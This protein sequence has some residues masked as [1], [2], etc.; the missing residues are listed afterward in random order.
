MTNRTLTSTA[1]AAILATVALTG[2]ASARAA[3]A[4]PA[5]PI[6]FLVPYP[7]GGSTDPIVRTIGQKLTEAW[8]QQIVIDNRAGAGGNLATDTTAKSAPDGYTLLL[9]T[10]STICINPSLY[11][12]LPFDPIKDLQP[13]SLV[14]SGFYLLAV[15]SG[16]PAASVKELVALAKSKPGQ[17]NYA[18]GGAGSAPHLAMELLKQMAH[19]DIA[20]VPYKGTGPALT[21][22]VGGHV[23]MLFGSAVSITP[24]QKAGR[25]RVLA[26]TG[27]QRSKT[28]PDIPTVAESGYPAFE[29]DSWYGCSCRRVPRTRSSHSFTARSRAAR[30]PP[31]CTL[32]LFL[33]AWN[34]SATSPRNSRGSS[35]MTSRAGR[36][37]SGTPI[38]GSTRVA[39]RNPVMLLDK[40]TAAVITHRVALWMFRRGV[41]IFLD[42]FSPR[43]DSMMAVFACAFAFQGGKRK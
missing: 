30:R 5:R 33:S 27:R 42:G 24:L 25:V 7:P 18:S 16:F 34:R 17:L 36:R 28:M 4:Y 12:K 10:V 37:S 43:D 1:T 38:S 39:D 15:N 22:V 41:L 19:I 21:D 31:T 6:R 35:R 14:A 3:D 13:V 29:V 23:P 32:A 40:F 11:A 9:G 2:V 8:G 26:M 20:H